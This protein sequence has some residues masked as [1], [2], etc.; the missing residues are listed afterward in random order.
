VSDDLTPDELGVADMLSSVG[1]P[2]R[3]LSAPQAGRGQIRWFAVV[4]FAALVAAVAAGV[5]VLP[6]AFGNHPERSKIVPAVSPSAVPT[7]PPATTPPVQ[8]EYAGAGARIDAGQ[9]LWLLGQSSLAVS[10]DGGMN[11]VQL[12]PP[13]DSSDIEAISVLPTETVAVTAVA[14]LSSVSIDT[15]AIGQ[16]AWQTHTISIGVGQVGTVQIV[17][18]NGTLEGLMV[19]LTS[20]AQF[21]DG[22]WLG[23]PDGGTSW[24][25]E[26]TPV[27]GAVGSVGGGIWLVGGV[28]NQDVYFSSDNGA[29]WELINIPTTVGGQV[30][31]GPVQANGSQVVLTATLANSGETQVV[32]GADSSSGWRWTDG[33]VLILAGQYGAGAPALSSVADGVLWIVSPANEVGL[34]TLSS[35]RVSQVMATGLPSNGTLSLSASS[36][37]DA[38]AVYSSSVCPAGK[39]ECSTEAGMVSTTDDGQVWTPV[40]DPFVGSS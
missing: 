3:R 4:G 25:S 36:R 17:D 29:S 35:G 20:S 34:V 15:V 26:N 8:A 18:S 2:R 21:S 31:Y 5:V 10:R 14:P 24:Q 40:A 16:T 22:V 12:P 37:L 6:Q 27:G 7:V 38:V 32:T 30:A 39:S 28:L 33:R 13:P 19:D 1:A 11:W 23:T 9:Y